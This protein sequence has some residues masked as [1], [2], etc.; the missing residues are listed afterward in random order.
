MNENR[1]SNHRKYNN[2]G[3]KIINIKVNGETKLLKG[4][5]EK[6]TDDFQDEKEEDIN[7]IVIE[8]PEKLSMTL[9]NEKRPN[10]KTISKP[11]HNMLIQLPMKPKKPEHIG[12]AL[13]SDLREYLIESI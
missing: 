2:S 7:Q 13:K 10:Y 9:K 6:V 4:K 1:H 11:K 3:Y 8:Q 5:G 12:E